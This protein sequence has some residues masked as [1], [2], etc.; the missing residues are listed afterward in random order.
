MQV[1]ILQAISE[2]LYQRSK[3]VLPG[4]GVFESEITPARADFVQGI[5]YPAAK[6]FT[7][8][9]HQTATED[10][11]LSSF[12]ATQYKLPA[13]QA[14]ESVQRFVSQ[15]NAALQH[16]DAIHI[17]EVGQLYRDTTHKIWFVPEKNKNYNTQVFGLPILE[18]DRIVRN[19]RQATG[20]LIP[21]EA[22]QLPTAAA[23]PISMSKGSSIFQ[24]IT[25]VQLLVLTATVLLLLTMALT[26]NATHSSGYS[27]VENKIQPKLTA[28]N[29]NVRPTVENVSKPIATTD[30][31]EKMVEP[32]TESEEITAEETPKAAVP[33]PKKRKQTHITEA[34]TE[35]GFKK[36][37]ARRCIMVIGCYSD[38]KNIAA[39]LHIIKTT[40]LKA[41]QDKSKNLTRIGITFNYSTVATKELMMARIKKQFNN[42]AWE[43]KK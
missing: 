18:F 10:N 2:L 6:T 29:T 35:V 4:I 13:Y 24:N 27:K 7:F 42:D 22:S 20:E 21:L 15:T 9:E 5:L 38:K 14:E 12:I 19:N 43:L 25:P 16:R 32:P 11:T 36:E 23:M 28:A 30:A 33:E 1:D 41:Y 26:C 39:K 3:L 17:P 31:I 34:S 8:S 40:G 37:T